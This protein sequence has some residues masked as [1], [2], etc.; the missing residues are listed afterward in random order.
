M[1]CARLA[2]DDSA[3]DEPA[4]GKRMLIWVA[5][6]PRCGNRLIRTALSAGWGFDGPSVFDAA[7]R[8]RAEGKRR[9][10]NPKRDPQIKACREDIG[11]NFL[12]THL[13]AHAGSKDRALLLIR[14]GR[15]SLV[16]YAHFMHQRPALARQRTYEQI[17]L[18][19]IERGGGDFGSWSQSVDA[20]TGRSAPTEIVRFERLRQDPLGIAREGV[21]LLGVDL[22]EP[23]GEMQSLERMRE[24]DPSVVRSG[25]VGTWRREMPA[26]A[27][28]RFA[29]LHGE[30]LV[31]L[32]YESSVDPAEWGSVAVAD[33]GGR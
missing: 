24:E 21:G 23:A 6:Y 10:P 8:A 28:E 20:W 30:T 27:V 14:D 5:S 11:P 22:G 19:L 26:A 18:W 25:R 31:R 13:L 32:G 12:K 3:S 9:L 33:G 17:L 7:E 4:A 15:D 29:Q 1:A 2:R 16:S